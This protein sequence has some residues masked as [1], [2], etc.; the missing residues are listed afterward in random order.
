M[1][2]NATA[3]QRD[4]MRSFYQAH[5]GDEDRVCKAFAD[6][7]LEGRFFRKAGD[8]RFP[9]EEYARA[10]FADGIA[11]GWLKPVRLDGQD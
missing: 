2:R 1:P 11:R 9:P 8:Y 5:R 6:A 4:L 3:F 10:L 7:E